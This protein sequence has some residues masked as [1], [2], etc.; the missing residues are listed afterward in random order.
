MGEAS[1]ESE[2]SIKRFLFG[3]D[4]HLMNPYLF[5]SWI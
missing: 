4:A 1:E 5:T 3:P 2:H